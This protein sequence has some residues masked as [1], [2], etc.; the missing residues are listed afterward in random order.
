MEYV[1]GTKINQAKEIDKLGV[2]RKKLARI[3]VESYLMQILRHGFFHADPHPGNVSVD[4]VGEGRL[5]YYDF[6]MMG[7]IPGN[8]KD[9]LVE[10]FYGVY[11]RD[12]EKC[13]E[14]LMEMGV[15]VKGG[16]MTAI[17]RTGEYFLSQFKVC[18]LEAR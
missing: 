17:T 16:D 3:T 8:V 10:L 9:G 7:R 5:I 13:I 12:V 18:Y 1:P 6:G 4:G 14:A 2:D 11:Q 15:L